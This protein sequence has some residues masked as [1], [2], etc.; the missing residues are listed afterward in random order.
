MILLQTATFF[1]SF[2][3]LGLR[4]LR[5]HGYSFYRLTQGHR[6]NVMTVLLLSAVL[7]VVSVESKKDVAPLK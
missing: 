5:L 4:V 1:Y 6:M 3:C 7:A 2:T